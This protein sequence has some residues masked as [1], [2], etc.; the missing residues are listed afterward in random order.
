[1]SGT[2]CSRHTHADPG[3]RESRAATPRLLDEV[4][5]RRK[6]GPCEFTLLVADVHRPKAADWTLETA[7]PLLRRAARAPVE[8]SAARP[9]TSTRDAV[10]DGSYDAII[11]STLPRSVSKWLR[12]DLVRQTERLGLPVTAIHTRRRARLQQGSRQDA[13]RVRARRRDRRLVGRASAD[14]VP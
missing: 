11:I 4:K 3:R 14:V 12:R 1:V 8:G 5:R 9:V 13:G 10:R 2:R 7:P 6:A